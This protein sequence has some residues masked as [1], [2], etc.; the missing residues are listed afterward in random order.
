[1]SLGRVLRPLS[2]KPW[3]SK[4]RSIR[5]SHG[6]IQPPPDFEEAD[7]QL[8]VPLADAAP[9]HAERRQHHLHRVADDV[10]GAATLEAVD[11]DLR[12]ARRSA[13]VEADREIELFAAVQNGS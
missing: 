2:L 3:S 1:M 13:L 12:H 5:S 10:L 4:W 6:A 9:D 11:A 8:R 7:A